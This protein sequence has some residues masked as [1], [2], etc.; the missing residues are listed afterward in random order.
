MLRASP[1]PPDAPAV[2]AP[3]FWRIYRVTRRSDGRGYVG[4]TCR[5]LATRLAAHV[6]LARRHPHLGR[7]GTLA[8]AIRTATEQGLSFSEAF[9]TETLDDTCS[10]DA[11]RS[12]ERDWIARLGTAWPR[13]FN[14]QPGGAS[15][16]GPAN[17]LPVTLCH[18]ER[19][20]L[21]YPSLL[22]AV[23]GLGEERRA[24]GQPPLSPGVVY[25][26][27]AMGWSLEE[28]LGLVPHQDGRGLRGD[29][30]WQGQPAASLRALARAQGIAPAALRSRLHRARRRDGTVLPDLARDRRH[31][32]SRR[33]CGQA[34]RPP[35]LALPH[36]ADP[37]APPVNAAVF[38]RLAGLPRATVLHRYHALAVR[39]GGAA[40]L[41][42]AELLRALLRRQEREIVLRLRLPGGRILSGGVRAL[43]RQVLGDLPLAGV[44]AEQLGASAIR[45]R[46]RRL[47]DWPR[48]GQAGIAWA[49]GFRPG[50]R[51]RGGAAAGPQDAS[52]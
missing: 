8:A 15:L 25:A 16:G 50:A 24:A 46:L 19:G 23:I 2:P 6:H 31:S 13:G 37:Q 1:P 22:A 27:R 33:M 20:M 38:A 43:I 34:A 5:S 10:P 3:R 32:A 18:P 29:V 40:G 51:P 35:C 7:P 39:P 36:P 47:P 42:R 28:A 9:L 11:A 21:R 41:T 12:L 26:R 17:A 14:V 48:P 4:V 52:A 49:F 30:R 45:A 44:R